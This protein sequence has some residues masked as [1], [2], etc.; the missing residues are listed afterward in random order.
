[1][2]LLD[3]VN[4]VLAQALRGLE[5][6]R[7]YQRD[8]LIPFL[9]ENPRS[10]AYVDMGLGKTVSVLTALDI[11]YWSG[12]VSKILIVAPLR[13]AV[14][15]W[16]TEI[17]EWRHT[18]WMHYSLI[19]PNPE[20]PEVNSAMR[21]ARR[22]DSL[23]PNHAAQKAKTMVL[24][25]QMG[26]KA[27]SDAPIH[28][29][30]REQVQWLVEFHGQKSWPYD[31]IIIDESTSFADHKS[32]R[33]KALASVAHRTR[34]I[35]LLSGTPA[36]EGIQDLFAQ[37]YL[38]DGG[39][40]FGKGITN[41]QKRYLVQNPY[42]RTWKPRPGA[43]EE[44]AKLC[45]DICLVMKEEDHLDV[46]KPLVIERPVVLDPDE[47]KRYKDF[48]RELILQ[49]P[50]DVEIEAVNS[51]VLSMKLLQYASG[52]VYDQDRTAHLIHS[53][54]IE[55]M[56]EIVDE[57]GSTPLL[58]AY[59]F[60][61]SL[62][63][64]RKAFP[65]SV[66]MDRNG[67]CVKDWNAGKIGMLLIHP[68]SAGHGLNLQLGPGHTLIFFDTPASLELY[69]QTIKRIARSGQK[70]LV[71]VIHLVARGTLDAL[72][73]PKL[74]AKESAQDIITDYLRKLRGK[75]IPKRAA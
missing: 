46:R 40:R 65:K 27:F 33:W 30:N 17:A 42:N 25:N 2:T 63:R 61:P 10:A 67:E 74:R 70:R 24:R 50:D 52:M 7:P 68:Q 3:A 55:E 14:Q 75:L 56:Q 29:I 18:A 23:S 31:T 51:G 45:A 49:L 69:L 39:K 38:L 11:L 26:E 57:L 53:H 6:L 43:V 48:E 59:W 54:K 44:V 21:D 41:F 62:D 66:V 20:A 64:L 4:A 37:I 34:R 16:P 19:R 73:V 71:K 5:D 12:R 72:V 28:I 36:P 22:R 1:M 58:V 13:V 35:H 32:A 60:K 47:L 8:K 15:T 9:V